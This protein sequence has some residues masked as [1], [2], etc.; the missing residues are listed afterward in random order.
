VPVDIFTLLVDYITC[1][2]SRSIYFYLGESLR[3]PDDQEWF[4]CKGSLELIE[5]LLLERTPDKQNIFFGKIVE[6][7]ADLRE[8]FNEVLIEI[9]KV[10]EALYFFEAFGDGPIYDGFKY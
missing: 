1:G 3:C 10:N 4:N 6:G 9:S 8:V 2:E 7:V 5:S